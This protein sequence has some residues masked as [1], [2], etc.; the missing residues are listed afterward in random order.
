MRFSLAPSLLSR[1]MICTAYVPAPFDDSDRF[2][3]Q[4][5][6][7]L[8]VLKVVRR[9]LRLGYKLLGL[10][11]REN[12]ARIDISFQTPQ[13]R[14]RMHE[15]KSARELNEVHVNQAALYWTPKWDE[16]AVSNG[17]R[18]LVLTVDQIRRVQEQAEVVRELL[19]NQPDLAASTFTPSDGVCNTCVN[20]KCLYLPK[21]AAIRSLP[22]RI[23][24]K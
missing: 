12:G 19:I 21:F 11:Q 6:H 15:V 23:E 1:K 22:V 3:F 13:G 17:D 18:D 8:A 9:H 2:R 14:M 5:L 4:A 10:E 16:V 20:H 7:A 24:K